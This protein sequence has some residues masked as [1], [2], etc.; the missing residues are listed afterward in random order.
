MGGGKD[1]ASVN[2]RGGNPPGIGIGGTPTP[3]PPGIIPNGGGGTPANCPNGGGGA[4][5]VAPGGGPESM[6][7]APERPS[8][9]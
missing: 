9:A 5:G 2:L 3:I 8:A 1:K 4:K 6:G 7:F